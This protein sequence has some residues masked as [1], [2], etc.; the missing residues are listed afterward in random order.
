[1]WPSSQPWM[2]SIY[3]RIDLRARLGANALVGIAPRLRHDAISRKRTLANIVTGIVIPAPLRRQ[4]RLRL[5]RC[6]RLG[7]D[8]LAQTTK[9][10]RR[11]RQL[12]P[13]T[14]YRARPRGGML[15]VHWWIVKTN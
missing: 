1:M 7:I 2:I 5:E 12:K 15:I 10:L 14:R 11:P 3:Q 4:L 8:C 6:N 9:S 13:F